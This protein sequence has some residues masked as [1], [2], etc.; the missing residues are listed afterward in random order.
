LERA[1]ATWW[2]KSLQFFSAWFR[3]DALLADKWLALVKRPKLI[4]PLQRIGINVALCSGRADFKAALREWQQGAKYIETLPIGL[5]RESLEPFQSGP[6]LSLRSLEGQG[7]D[8]DFGL[9][10]D[11]QS[12]NPHPAAKNAARMGHP[13]Y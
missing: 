10:T 5:V 11:D 2:R 8:F 6:S 12:Q 9:I 4:Q 7:G 1:L 3:R 13:E